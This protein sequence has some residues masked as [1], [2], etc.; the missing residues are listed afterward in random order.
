MFCR[1]F[2]A[3][4]RGRIALGALASTFVAALALNPAP[5]FPAPLDAAPT[6][7]RFEPTGLKG[8]FTPAVLP[9]AAN[10][11][12]PISVI[13]ELEEAP[14][15][16]TGG[17]AADL[18]K[19]QQPL[20]QAIAGQ[21][22]T[23][24]R[25]YQRAL[26]GFAVRTTRG[27][28]A[29]LAGLSSVRKVTPTR[30]Y[31]VENARS[32][33]YIGAPAVWQGSPGVDGIHGE[34]VK[35]GIIDTGLDY[36]HANFGGP[37]TVAAYDAA[38]ASDT[39]PADPTLF[40][41]NS[42]TNVKGGI[43]LVGDDYDSRGGDNPAFTPRPD[44]NPLDCNGH[45]SHVAGTAAGL[46]VNADGTTYRGPYNASTAAQNFRIGPGVA[47][48]ADL[49]AIRVFGCA[50]SSS[51][52]VIIAGIEWAVEHKL[53]V[54]N[55]SL[56]SPLGT[57]DDDDP[58]IHAVNNAS[59]AGTMVVA[60]A[61]NS[62]QNPY[63]VGAPGT[64]DRAL[65]VSANDA[66]QSIQ[67]GAALGLSTGPSVNAQ[68]SNLAT[69][70]GG[71]F[72]VK[73][74]RDAGGNISL[75]C[76]SSEYAGTAGMVVVSMRGV[77]ARTDRA[78]YAQRA[79]AAAAVMINSTDGFPPV[80]GAISG[81]TIPFL[82]VAND[83]ATALNAADG[84]TA[85]LRSVDSP[86]PTFKQ[87]AGFTSGGPRLGDN[88]LKPEV[89]APGVKIV[90]TDVG[91]GNGARTLSG[92]SMAAPHV[93]GLAALVTQSHPSSW[94]AEDQKQAI[95]NTASP[96]QIADY[97]TRIAGAGMVQAQPATK[98]L[99][100]A[101]GNSD[102]SSLSFGFDVDARDLHEQGQL[103]VRNHGPKD[104][105]FNLS[106]EFAQ[107]SPH[108][109]SFERAS[110]RVPAGGD[111]S[112]SVRLNVPI[113]TAGDSMAFNTVSGVVSLTPTDGGNNG[114]A[115][116]VPYFLV[117]R[118]LTRVQEKL[119]GELNP[120]HPKAT[121]RV[122][123]PDGGIAGKADFYA[124]G[125]SDEQ[126]RPLSVDG[127]PFELRSA[128]VQATDGGN[129][130]VFALNSRGQWTTP[131]LQ[132]FY[133]QLTFPDGH[134]VLVW[135]ADFG[136]VFNGTPDGRMGTF[137]YNLETF[138][139]FSDFFALAPNN[140]NTILLPVLAVQLGM[141]EAN[142]RFDY[143]A[144][145]FDERTGEPSVLPGRG[146]FNAF[147]SAITNGRLEQVDRGRTV[148]VPVSLNVAEAAITPAKGLMIVSLDNVAKH[149]GQVELI[150][151]PMPAAS[152]SSVRTG[153]ASN[154]HPQRAG[155]TFRKGVH[156]LSP[157]R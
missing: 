70:P 112:T 2:G 127:K 23:V 9:T 85:T 59:Q 54:V 108:S 78:I 73:V 132:E 114:V 68:N 84:G 109:V 8:K 118:A 56:G 121:V 155:D 147:T 1:R 4:P 153:A 137:V 60:S 61:G 117:P 80:D 20:K 104:I 74:L 129:T 79:G 18:E 37:G 32:V 83:A 123:N 49:Y 145:A 77:C 90:S 120:S 94:S 140:S 50:G 5:A 66:I 86:N 31:E 133:V 30:V 88:F 34:G 102:K 98:T 14:V 17:N 75:G 89:A 154:G 29:A 142:P 55:M 96:G 24:T 45:G 126:N 26:N 12:D 6:K 107:G 57:G 116:R 144:F 53:D 48:K 148:E 19:R 67:G 122:T 11:N 81:V 62:G 99:A 139:F 128:G 124:W 113:A 150:D 91:T 106:Q 82:G 149:G 42:I 87:Q 115:L 40:G 101:F 64:A 151:V 97:N 134:Q 41:P 46:G 152:A 95:V 39:Q 111:A 110:L 103:L 65:T 156:K 136:R 100:V 28:A 36:T 63:L 33:P 138:E 157:N 146:H 3:R 15:G 135:A 93:T 7:Q 16:A 21:G 119:V 51:S 38:N 131:T 35:V 22:G 71:T 27:K 72:R 10:P 105:V 143:E 25:S 44:P 58:E 52:E 141:S 125:Q 47:P 76:D 13:V 130:I 92:T 69:V 43:D